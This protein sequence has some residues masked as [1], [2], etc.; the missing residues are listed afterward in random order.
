MD[1]YYGR[2]RLP[3][4]AGFESGPNHKMLALISHCA[5]PPVRR[6]IILEMAELPPLK[7]Y[8]FTLKTGMA[9]GHGA[10]FSYQIPVYRYQ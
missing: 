3:L 9:R 7:G 1:F 8:L 6:K 2:K 5:S 4:S 10:P